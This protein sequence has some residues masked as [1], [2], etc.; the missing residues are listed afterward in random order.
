MFSSSVRAAIGASARWVARGLGLAV[1]MAAAGVGAAEPWLRV[2]GSERCSVPVGVLAARIRETTIGTP[3]PRLT[4]DVSISDGLPTTARVR[5]ALG[6][7]GIG[8]KE[9]EAP[10]CAEVLDA[11]TTVVALALSSESDASELGGPREHSASREDGASPAAAASPA[12][13]ALPES[14]RPASAAVADAFAAQNELGRDTG[15]WRLLLGVGA[16]RGS[17]SEPTLVV[18]AGAAVSLGR[19]EVRALVSYGVPS[20]REE[21]SD[22]FSSVH[23]DFGALALDYCRALDAER[24]VSACA[25]LELGLRRYSRVEQAAEGARIE[26]ERFEPGTSVLGGLAFVYR[27]A[28][29]QPRLDVMAGRALLGAPAEAPPLGFRAALGAAVQF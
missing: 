8:V 15:G 10:T 24:W 17:L 16:D 19:G 1:G 14:T 23:A 25:G 13:A 5:L 29:V 18:Q 7:R 28:A 11:V 9:L 21:E 27:D 20:V 4:V 26:R 12:D 2:R 6:S 22:V 3:D